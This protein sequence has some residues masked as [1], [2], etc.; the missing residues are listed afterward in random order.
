MA[1]PATK[2]TLKRVVDFEHAVQSRPVTTEATRAVVRDTVRGLTGAAAMRKGFGVWL[3]EVGAGTVG[4]SLVG[5]FSLTGTLLAVLMFMSGASCVLGLVDPDR[6]G[7]NVALFLAILIGGQWL[8]LIIAIAIW[9]LRSRAN[10]GLS[11]VGSLLAKFVQKLAGGSER[12]DWDQLKDAGRPARAVIGWRFAR[13]SQLG[14]ISFNVG[15]A[16]GLLGLVLVRQIGF[17]WETTTE[18]AMQDGLE[19]GVKLLAAPWVG[20]WE[21][22]VPNVEVIRD[23]Q[24]KFGQSGVLTGP[25]EWWKFLFMST[26]VWGLFPRVFLWIFAWKSG[27]AALG[28]LDFQGRSHRSL[29]RELTGTERDTLTGGPLDGVL[30]LDVG[31]SKISET[32]LRPFLHCKLRVNPSSWL[33][34][35]VFDSGAEEQMQ[36]AIAAAPAGVVLLSEGWSLSPPRLRRLHENLRKTLGVRVSIKFLVVNLTS[37]GTLVPPT[38][39]ER[40]EWE[41][42]VDGLRDPEA[43][44]FTFEEP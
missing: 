13:L 8:L 20:W 41:K 24:W 22:A 29:W 43:E 38:D 4:R 14:G 40:T 39:I 2:W 25:S 12:F 3:T 11:V 9:L 16:S 1:D 28:S 10:A 35:G 23:S 17:Y 21:A 34:V 37:T 15:I 31:G 42:F 32:S 19:A 36:Q 33:P 5:A 7:I 26:L 27:K 44:I 18:L 6:R 30:V